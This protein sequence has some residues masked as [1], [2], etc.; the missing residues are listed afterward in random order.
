MLTIEEFVREV[1]S[2]DIHNCYQIHCN[3][4]PFKDSFSGNCEC[5]EI[6]KYKN[7]SRYEAS[8]FLA[9]KYSWTKK[10]EELL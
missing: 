9:E 7:Y 1:Y 3:D 8:K 10:I 2:T 6:V 4:C 5:T